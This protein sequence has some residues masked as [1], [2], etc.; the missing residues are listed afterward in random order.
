MHARG[1]AALRGHVFMRVQAHAV[2]SD[3]E[4]GCRGLGVVLFDGDDLVALVDLD[5][6]EAVFEDIVF[7]PVA[8]FD[9]ARLG[10]EQQAPRRQLFARFKEGDGPLPFRGVGAEVRKAEGLVFQPA[11]VNAGKVYLVAVAALGKAVDDLVGGGVQNEREHVGEGRPLAEVLVRHGEILFGDDLHLVRR[12]IHEHA[13][14][15]GAD[16]VKLFHLDLVRVQN[17]LAAALALVLFFDLAQFFL[18]H[19]HLQFFALDDGGEFGD[20]LFQLFQLLLQ[21]EDL[22]LGQARQPEVEDGLRLPLGEVERL[23]QAGARHGHAF[24]GLDDLDDFVDVADGDD[25]PFQDMAALFGL[26]QVEAGAAQHH[27]ALVGDV[28]ADD[29]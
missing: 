8:L 21:L 15:G 3:E 1:D 17:Q 19:L 13:G 11:G 10:E 7:L 5:R 22:Q 24:A 29:V 14:H 23:P 2:L 12:R 27:L 6:L 9:V 28:V 4:E 18:H 16:V 26:R 20:E 25:Q